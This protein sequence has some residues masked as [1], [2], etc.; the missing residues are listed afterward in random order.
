MMKAFFFPKSV[1]VVGASEKPGK[2]G[3]VIVKNL[4]ALGYPGRIF[5]VNPHY[6]EVLGLEA[7]PNISSLPLKPELVVV[8]VPPGPAVKVLEE[9]GKA[10]VKHAVVITAGFGER[11]NDALTKEFMRVVR[12]YQMKVIGPNCLGVS[13]RKFGFD[14]VF[15]P[16]HKL[17]RPEFGSV[18]VISQSG[19]IGTSLLA[20]AY[21]EGVGIGYFV[22]YGNAYVLDESDFIEYFSEQKD[23]DTI[24]LYIE[25]VKDGRKLYR[26][27]SKAVSRRKRVVVLKAG[28][29]AEA[30]K[31]AMTHTGAI[32]GNY[33]SYLAAFRKAN[34]IE[35]ET[36]EEMF[37]VLKVLRGIKKSFGRN[38]GII[39]NGGGLGVLSVDEIDPSPFSLAKLS[40]ES[41]KKLRESMPPTVKV[42]NPLDVIADASTDRFTLALEAFEKDPG[43]DWVLLNIL[44]QSPA[45]DETIIKP[46][47]WLSRQKP[48][49]VVAP[50]GGIAEKYRE[51]L[52]LNDIIV[53]EEPRRAVN[54]VGKVWRF[55]ERIKKRS[56]TK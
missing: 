34:V 24:L 56:S 5:P 14:T 35:V 52:S 26:A 27:L 32:A 13:S 37:D 28:K 47:V 20:K 7:Y 46:I 45:V 33:L 16:I 49:V 48:I 41:V 54:A 8:A 15:F 9:A 50:G 51:V 29:T 1:A 31:A 12:K 18:A 10:G 43:V 53:F 21:E 17:R 44:F 23:V 4:L 30:G 19:G 39:T 55:Y 3:N 40:K 42:E 22:S 11:G 25:G 36:L 6:E 38:V 2:V